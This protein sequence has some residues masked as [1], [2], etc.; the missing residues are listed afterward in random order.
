MLSANNIPRSQ[1]WQIRDA[2]TSGGPSIDSYCAFAQRLTDRQASNPLLALLEPLNSNTW[3]DKTGPGMRNLARF[4]GSLGKTTQ[5]RILSGSKF[6]IS[7]LP[8][9]A[10]K[11]L[12]AACRALFTGNPEEIF[13]G[14]RGYEYW[15]LPPNLPQ[16]IDWDLSQTGLGALPS[17]IVVECIRQQ[18]EPV[19]VTT[20]QL[21]ATRRMIS[22]YPPRILAD[23]APSETNPH[24]TSGV[25]WD[26][27]REGRGTGF[28]L[29]VSFSPSL[30]F[31]IG[32][33]GIRFAATSSPTPLSGVS[34]TLKDAIAEASKVE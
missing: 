28:V 24:G 5:Q 29:K 8:R 3:L 10:T 33:R 25:D 2:Y 31:T 30:S 32:Y 21:D 13:I 19:A 20:A 4:W 16:G 9:A 26:H 11:N 34:K 17:N 22:V 12:Y 23:Y 27:I 1:L 18:D 14:T 6:Q 15:D 7:E